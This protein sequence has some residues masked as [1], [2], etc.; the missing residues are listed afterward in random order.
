MNEI[1]KNLFKDICQM[2]KNCQSGGLFIF[3]GG[4]GV[5]WGGDGVI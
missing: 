4:G 3:D 5:F 1:Q 2:K